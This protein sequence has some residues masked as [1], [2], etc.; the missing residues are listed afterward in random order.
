MAEP[1]IGKS[2]RLNSR[3]AEI[4]E[5][6]RETAAQNGKSL[7]GVIIEFLREYVKGNILK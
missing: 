5:V 6:A 1:Q 7:K 3:E 2:L 4:W